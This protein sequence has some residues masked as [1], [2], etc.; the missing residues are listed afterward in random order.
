MFRRKKDRISSK[1]KKWDELWHT[2]TKIIL[3]Y[4]KI[5]HNKTSVLKT[6]QNHDIYE[7]V[8]FLLL[9]NFSL[10]F[11]TFDFCLTRSSD[12]ST[13]EYYHP[14]FKFIGLFIIWFNFISYLLLFCFVSV[15]IWISWNHFQEI[16]PLII[17]YLFGFSR[18]CCRYFRI[19][20]SSSVMF[21][22]SM[23]CVCVCMFVF[24]LR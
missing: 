7:H 6:K 14:F 5:K 23:Y 11:Q 15:Y 24:I 19:L 20:S 9:T 22:I 17:I 12:F 2:H 21:E 16:F 4:F 10:N 8:T 13:G 3:N 18:C 1:K